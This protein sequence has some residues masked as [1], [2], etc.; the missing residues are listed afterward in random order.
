MAIECKKVYYINDEELVEE[1]DKLIKKFEKQKDGGLIQT[2]DG[3]DRPNTK[4]PTP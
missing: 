4:P 2:L 1:I 3:E